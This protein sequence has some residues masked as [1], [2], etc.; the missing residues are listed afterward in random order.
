MPIWYC[1]FEDFGPAYPTTESG[2]VVATASIVNTFIQ[3]GTDDRTSADAYGIIL[4][5]KP[6][7][8]AI[9]ITTKTIKRA[10]PEDFQYAG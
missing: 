5:L 10:L 2:Y 3:C 4:F 8:E 6:I 9:E 1:W 7:F